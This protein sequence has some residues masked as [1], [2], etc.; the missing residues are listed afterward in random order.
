MALYSLIFADVP[1]RIYSL[2]HCDTVCEMSWYGCYWTD[3]WSGGVE[4]CP[5]SQTCPPQEYLD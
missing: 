1:L 4:I 2:T 5:P 3:Q